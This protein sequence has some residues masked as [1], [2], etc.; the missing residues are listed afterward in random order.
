MPVNL[1][2]IYL[3]FFAEISCYMK[4]GKMMESI[5][6]AFGHGGMS[7][8]GILAISGMIP[9]FMGIMFIVV[10]A[11][12]LL[13][14]L[15]KSRSEKNERLDEIQTRTFTLLHFLR[16]KVAHGHLTAKEADEYA[17]EWQDWLKAN[18]NGSVQALAYDFKASVEDDINEK[19]RED[20]HE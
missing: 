20:Q 9:K 3:S 14:L 5:L 2:K 15:Q 6:A 10:G 17:A 13:S 16:R 19:L 8:G 18:P 1:E 7:H 4:G 12:N 11:I